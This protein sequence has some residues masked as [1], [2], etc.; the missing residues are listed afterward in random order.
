MEIKLSEVKQARHDNEMFTNLFHE[1]FWDFREWLKR[2]RFFRDHTDLKELAMNE[3]YK[4]IRENRYHHKK[5]EFKQWCQI[6]FKQAILDYY[7]F[8]NYEKRKLGEYDFNFNYGLIHEDIYFDFDYIVSL[9]DHKSSFIVNCLYYNTWSRKQIMEYM[10]ITS[11]RYTYYIKK[12]RKI[13]LKYI[14]GEI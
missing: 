4:I 1:I 10:E 12:A 2:N 3:F 8:K 7:R 13:F 5:I 9:L 11:E 14:N 6:K